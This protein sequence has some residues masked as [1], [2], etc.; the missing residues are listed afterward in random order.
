MRPLLLVLLAGV[1]AVDLG[2][3]TYNLNLIVE[4]GKDTY[5]STL[6]DAD[7]LLKHAVDNGMGTSVQLLLRSAA[8]KVRRSLLELEAKQAKESAAA[9][10]KDEGPPQA[11]TN[12]SV[13]VRAL[14]S[15]F[16]KPKKANAMKRMAVADFAKAVEENKAAS[17]LKKPLI[18]EGGVGALDGSYTRQISN[19][20]FW[21]FCEHVPL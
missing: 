10:T 13:G 1:T 9:E 6:A 2:K 14:K 16:A 17:L 15:T 4:A 5:T 8:D 18:V 12:T 11:L 3:T 19:P 7:A 20:P 21:P